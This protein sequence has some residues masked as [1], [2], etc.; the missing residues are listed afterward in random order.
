MLYGPAISQSGLIDCRKTGPYQLP[1]YNFEYTSES[2]E[3][4][5]RKQEHNCIMTV[6]P[7]RLIVNNPFV[8][9]KNKWDLK[10]RRSN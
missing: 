6:L 10:A 1:S 2:Y 8:V 4:Q 7:D 5:I 3:S 9:I